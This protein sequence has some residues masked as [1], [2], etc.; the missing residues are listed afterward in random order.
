LLGRGGVEVVVCVIRR[1][2]SIVE[3]QEMCGYWCW[4]MIMVI[5]SF[6]FALS[7]HACMHIKYCTHPSFGCFYF[8]SF[9][10]DLKERNR[11]VQ[12]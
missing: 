8:Q 11:R 12:G 3:G 9:A 5:L 6:V 2:E 4:C 10:L 7:L 1:A